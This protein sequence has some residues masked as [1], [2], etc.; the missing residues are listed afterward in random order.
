MCAC[1]CMLRCVFVY[2]FVHFLCVFCTFV[3]VNLHI[4]LCDLSKNWAHP[5]L[6]RIQLSKV[7]DFFLIH[8]KVQLWH[9]ENNLLLFFAVRTHVQ[10]VDV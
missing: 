2:V 5:H 6:K 4:I 1:L 7:N 10:S 3:H 9:T 8:L